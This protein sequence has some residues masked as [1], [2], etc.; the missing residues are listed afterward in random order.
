M[1]YD[2]RYYTGEDLAF[3]WGILL[4]N[5]KVLVINKVLSFY[6]QHPGSITKINDFKLFDFYFAL[7]HLCEDYKDLNT[8]NKF[9]N[10]IL[11]AIKEWSFFNF[12]HNARFY[13]ESNSIIPRK[14][15]KNLQ[16]YRPELYQSVLN[17]VKS[18][19]KLISKVTFKQKIY[20]WLFKTSPSVFLNTWFYLSR[21][22]KFF[23]QEK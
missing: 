7:N 12:L 6:V 23:L 13:L 15:L 3:E 14:F 9:I 18:I 5:P 22:K 2:E 11:Q 16:K 8:T 21:L 10:D 17:D 1:V 20:F 19:K 4:K